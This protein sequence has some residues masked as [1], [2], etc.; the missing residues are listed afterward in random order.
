MNLALLTEPMVLYQSCY[1]PRE[2]LDL[3]GVPIPHRWREPQ[4]VGDWDRCVNRNHEAPYPYWEVLQWI[5][6]PFHQSRVPPPPT[7]ADWLRPRTGLPPNP[8]AIE[9]YRNLDYCNCQ[10][11]RDWHE[12]A[13]LDSLEFNWPIIPGVF[14]APHEC[15]TSYRDFYCEHCYHADPVCFRAALFATALGYWCR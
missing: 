13:T 3:E 6:E 7:T 14:S 15:T 12:K 2:E 8:V 9:M 10:R 11:R 1:D 4:F 5:G